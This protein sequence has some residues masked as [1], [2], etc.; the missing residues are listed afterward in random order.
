[1]GGHFVTGHVD[2]VGGVVAQVNQGPFWE[3]TF[4]A[5]PHVVKYLAPKGSIAVNGV[6]LTVARTEENRFTVAAIPYSLDNTNLLMLTPGTLVNVEGDIL[7]KYV[8]RMLHKVTT[9]EPEVDFEFLV[10]HGYG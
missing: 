9:I 5:P 8:E 6:S 7:A 1:V 4:W 2:G 3:I 10:S